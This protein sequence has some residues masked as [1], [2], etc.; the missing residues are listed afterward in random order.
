MPKMTGAEFMVQ[1]MKAYGVTHAFYM[2]MIVTQALVEMEKAG[3]RRIMAH[4]E[5]GAAYMADGYAGRP[6]GLGS[7]WRR[8]WVPP[9]WRPGCKTLIWLGLQSSPLP[10]VGRRCS[11]TDT[12]TRK[13]TTCSPSLR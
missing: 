9:T 11:S 13:L 5:K 3:I 4:S 1:M 8:T 6:I 12:P 7:V 2:P 10:V